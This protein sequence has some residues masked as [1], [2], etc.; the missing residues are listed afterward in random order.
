MLERTLKRSIQHNYQMIDNH[1]Q[2]PTE[3]AHVNKI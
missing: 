3:L 2:R 1:L